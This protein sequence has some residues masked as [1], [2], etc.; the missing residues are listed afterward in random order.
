MV[1][2][3]LGMIE[4]V[5]PYILPDID[6]PEVTTNIARENAF[7]HHA[8]HSNVNCS[9]HDVLLALADEIVTQELPLLGIQPRD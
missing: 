1:G 8:P 5:S 6:R 9:G 2:D 3:G 4:Q 7:L